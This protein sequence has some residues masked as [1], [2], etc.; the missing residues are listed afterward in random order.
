MQLSPLSRRDVIRG[1]AV[2]GVGAATSGVAM[3]TTPGA[4]AAASTP[5]Q[6]ETRVA[7]CLAD[8]WKES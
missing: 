2:L 7:E 8:I 3:L 4:L 1:A 6:A 5:A